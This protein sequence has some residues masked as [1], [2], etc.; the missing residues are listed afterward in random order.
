M[1]QTQGQTARRSGQSRRR[2]ADRPLR[3]LTLLRGAC[4][5]DRECVPSRPAR[6]SERWDGGATRRAADRSRTAAREAAWLIAAALRTVLARE[7]SMARK[8][9]EPWG[10]EAPGDAARG[11]AADRIVAEEVRRAG[12][13]ELVE[14]SK[15]RLSNI[16]DRSRTARE[17][18]RVAG[19][20]ARCRI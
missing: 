2:A 6:T 20:V 19:A 3:R 14:R 16:G 5:V 12:G 7:R 9:T 10:R 4:G 8:G 11:G 18:S 15:P 1:V 13:A 17:G